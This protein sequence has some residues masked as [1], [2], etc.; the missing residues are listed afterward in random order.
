MAELFDNTTMVANV[1]DSVKPEVWWKYVQDNFY[2]AG[3][4]ITPMFLI[5]GL[6]GNILTILIMSSKVFSGMT[7]RY[8]L[9]ALAISD[10]TLLLTQ[11]FN[12]L[13][14]RKMIGYDVRAISDVGCKAFFHI[15]K[16]G[17]M[18][19]SWLIV[20]LCFERFIAVV[21][22]FKA[23]AIITIKSIM[24]LIILDYLFI[25]IFNAVW[26]FSSIVV[27][28][29]CKPDITYA[30]TKEK[31]RDYLIAGSSFYSLIP[32]IVMAIMTP[33][34]V[35]RLLR[36]KK[37]RNRMSKGGGASAEKADADT[38][39]ISVMLIGV[40]VAY[41]AFVLPI[42]VVH[43]LA[44]WKSVS[45]F[46]TNTLQFFLMREVAQILE[47]LNYAVNFVLYVLCSTKFRKRAME[48]LH[49]DGCIMKLAQRKSS[50]KNTSFTN[51]SGQKRKPGQSSCKD[52]ENG[53]HSDTGASSEQADVEK[54]PLCCKT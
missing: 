27:D 46:D 31:Y 1:T 51:L 40:V 39:R 5:F 15:F 19:S 14:V 26:T 6:F 30:H 45:V 48:I 47:Q 50:S 10:T 20:I 24:A 34:I 44:F 25:G 52:N 3:Y 13:F 16:T 32:M 9:I 38:L 7:S 11:P 22:P 12:K 53:H 4:V 28:G 36:Q 43:N 2:T 29:V 17:K 18:T 23:K 41:I 49:I 8:I 42:T 35:Y 54:P 37:I 21:F 33:V